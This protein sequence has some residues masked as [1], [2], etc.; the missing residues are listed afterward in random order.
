MVESVAEFRGQVANGFFDFAKAGG[1]LPL[2]E[3]LDK[4]LSIVVGALSKLSLKELDQDTKV[5]I[6]RYVDEAYDKFIRPI[7][8]PYVP[9]FAEQAVDDVLNMALNAAVAALLGL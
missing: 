8:L 4:L 5:A 7:D 1:R 6:A 9:N 3:A 2:G